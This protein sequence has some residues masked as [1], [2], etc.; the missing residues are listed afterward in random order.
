MKEFE[1]WRQKSTIVILNANVKPKTMNESMI[2]YFFV[3]FKS[4]QL[5]VRERQQEVIKGNHKCSQISIENWSQKN[6][7]NLIIY[8]DFEEPLEG[9]PSFPDNMKERK[10]G[11]SSESHLFIFWIFYPFLQAFSVMQIRYR[12]V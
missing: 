5:M 6:G 12:S 9:I 8:E 7:R 2:Y 3:F 10:T 1:F 11:K 4:C